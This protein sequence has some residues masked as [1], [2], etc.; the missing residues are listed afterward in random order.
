MVIVDDLDM[1]LNPYDRADRD[2]PVWSEWHRIMQ[3]GELRLATSGASNPEWHACEQAI[4]RFFLK[5]M[6]PDP[7]LDFCA[8]PA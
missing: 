1:G 4:V 2:D 7:T 6:H 5:K 3:D 8:G